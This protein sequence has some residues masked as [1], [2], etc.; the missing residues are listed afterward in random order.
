[1]NSHQ[2]ADKDLH[3]TACGDS[4]IFSAGEQEL[5]LLR[6]VQHQPERCPT[7]TRGHAAVLVKALEQRR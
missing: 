2:L 1:M 7:C 4:F 3:C 5:Y 6:G